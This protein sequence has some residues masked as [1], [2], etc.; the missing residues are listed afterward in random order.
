MEDLKKQESQDFSRT[1]MRKE[2]VLQKLKERGGRITKQRRLILDIILEGK[3]SCC[4]E[5]YYQAIRKDSSIGMSTVY[6]MVNIL[7]ELG[8]INRNHVYEIQ[9][10]SDP[11][12]RDVLVDAGVEEAQ[13]EKEACMLEQILCDDSYLKLKTYIE[14]RKDKGYLI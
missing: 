10:Q 6:R 5:I 9:G 7:E 13:A 14:K 3:C 11:F 8:A 12:F 1:Q 2:A 4:K